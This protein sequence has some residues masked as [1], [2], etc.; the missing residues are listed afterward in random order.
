MWW[1]IGVGVAVVAVV[2][3]IVGVACAKWVLKGT[4]IMQWYHWA[5]GAIGI[6]VAGVAFGHWVF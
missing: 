5:I 2:F 4:E 1:Y 3:W 6:W